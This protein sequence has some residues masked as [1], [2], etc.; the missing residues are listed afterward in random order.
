MIE[1]KSGTAIR[2]KQEQPSEANKKKGKD[3]PKRAEKERHG[4]R[5]D[6]QQKLGSGSPRRHGATGKEKAKLT[7]LTAG[8]QRAWLELQPKLDDAAELITL[9]DPAPQSTHAEAQETKDR[10]RASLRLPTEFASTS[11]MSPAASSGELTP[12]RPMRSRPQG[13]LRINPQGG[14][15]KRMSLPIT[16]PKSPKRTVG[17]LK[18]MHKQ[19]MAVIAQYRKDLTAIDTVSRE[20]ASGDASEAQVALKVAREEFKRISKS[21][22]TFETE[23]ARLKS[24]RLVV[25]ASIGSLDRLI[26]EHPEALFPED[27]DWC[28]LNEAEGSGLR[29]QSPKEHRRTQTSNM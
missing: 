27:D 28:V 29:P 5:T 2:G 17:R 13:S 21:I 19:D 18:E 9:G 15:G 4:A 7:P 16:P 25:A 6:V 10:H 8:A 24:Q 26:A 11:K 3:L 22:T 1:N 12:A 14:Q 23:I 20:V